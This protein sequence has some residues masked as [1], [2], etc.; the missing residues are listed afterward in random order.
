MYTKVQTYTFMY[1]RV[2]KV[3]SHVL[4]VYSMYVTYGHFPYEKLS[5]SSANFD[6]KLNL[7]PSVLSEV[8]N[9]GRIFVSREILYKIL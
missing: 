1:S 7:V 2:M 8:G 6:E 5:F 3:D 4:K 9:I